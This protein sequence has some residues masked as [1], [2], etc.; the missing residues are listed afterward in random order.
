MKIKVH[1]AYAETYEVNDEVFQTLYNI[2]KNDPFDQAPAKVYE[3]AVKRVENLCGLPS[4]D[5]NIQDEKCIIGVYA[6]D[7]VA[8]LEF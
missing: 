1:V 3:E 8:I 4:W 2:H 6:E 7:D 5:E